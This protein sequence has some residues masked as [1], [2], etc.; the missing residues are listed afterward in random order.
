MQF[1]PEIARE[2]SLFC[3]LDQIPLLFGSV[4]MQPIG[5]AWVMVT[6]SV[7]ISFSRYPSI[8]EAFDREGS[9]EVEEDV[10]MPG[11]LVGVEE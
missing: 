11:D 2:E 7:E 10:V 9:I 3:L 4:H 8:A 6:A 1:L 5:T